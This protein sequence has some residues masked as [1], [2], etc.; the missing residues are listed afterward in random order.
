MVK[1]NANLS[2]QNPSPTTVLEASLKKVADILG[3]STYLAQKFKSSFENDF[4]KNEL[5]LTDTLDR[6]LKW[7]QQLGTVLEKLPNSFHL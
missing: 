5:S 2:D 4:L 3:G 1:L 6:L 7:R